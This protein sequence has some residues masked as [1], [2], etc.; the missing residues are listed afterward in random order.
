MR[1]RRFDFNVAYPETVN[2]D[3]Q[4]IPVIHTDPFGSYTGR[5][6]DPF[7]IPIQDADDL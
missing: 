2:A 4:A 5:G 7:E 1:K 6:E 3:H